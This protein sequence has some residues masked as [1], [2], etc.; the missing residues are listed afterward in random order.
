[1]GDGTYGEVVLVKDKKSGIQSGLL[2]WIICYENYPK[3][4]D[5][6][7]IINFK[8]PFGKVYFSSNGSSICG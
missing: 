4:D 3:V 7:K 6:W 5:H 8:C 2:R 1:M